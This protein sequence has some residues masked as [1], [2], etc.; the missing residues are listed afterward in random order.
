MVRS[1]AILV[2]DDEPEILGT[3]QVTLERSGYRVQTATD[4]QSGLARA[5]R[6]QPDLVVVDLMTPRQSGFIVLERLKEQRGPGFP[7]IMMSDNAAPEQRAYAE[8]LGADEF[9]LK[10]IGADELLRAVGRFLPRPLGR[11]PELLEGQVAE[12]GILPSPG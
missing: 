5:V 3:L 7:V 11:H 6:E 1:K 8:F 12:E 10:P 9:L 4:G 2:I